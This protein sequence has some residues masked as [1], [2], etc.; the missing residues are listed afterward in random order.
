MLFTVEKDVPR[1]GGSTIGRTA[2]TKLP[3]YVSITR[4]RPLPPRPI[5]RALPLVVG[6][7]PW[8]LVSNSGEP[9]QKTL[10][11]VP[12]LLL[13]IHRHLVSVP[14]ADDRA[15]LLVDET[16]P[17]SLTSAAMRSVHVWR[18]RA[19]TRSTGYKNVI[20]DRL[21]RHGSPDAGIV[22]FRERAGAVGSDMGPVARRHNVA[23]RHCVGRDSNCAGQ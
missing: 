17:D 7:P 14:E 9:S 22:G 19:W 11:N 10:S 15:P 20:D 3:E 2:N 6:P 5:E 18:C 12:E 23:A 13:L 16:R 1:L 21:V 4:W 8:A